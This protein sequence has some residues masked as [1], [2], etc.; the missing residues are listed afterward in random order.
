M[1]FHADGEFDPLQ[2]II[3]EMSS[4]PMVNLTSANE[5][6]PKIERRFFC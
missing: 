2:E 1:S 3:A 5:H 6:V 4:G